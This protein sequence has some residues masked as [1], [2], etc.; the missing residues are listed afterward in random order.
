MTVAKAKAGCVCLDDLKS[1]STVFN[2]AC[3]MMKFASQQGGSQCQISSYQQE[4]IYQRQIH[5]GA[6]GI[7]LIVIIEIEWIVIASIAPH[8]VELAIPPRRRRRQSSSAMR[9][10]VNRI[11]KTGPTCKGWVTCHALTGTDDPEPMFR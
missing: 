4:R 3:H 8:S 7:M 11:A 10:R 5:F 1:A 6:V 2:L 9:Y